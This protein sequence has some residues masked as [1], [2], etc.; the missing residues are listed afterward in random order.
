MHQVFFRIPYIEWPIYGFGLMLFLAF[1]ACTWLASRRA[2]RVGMSKEIVQDFTI[3]IFIGGLLGARIFFI[4]LEETPP[5]SVGEFLYRLPR[6]W[7]G[8]IIF[9]GSVVGALIAYGLLYWF[10][11]RK[12]GISTLKLADVVAPSVALGLALGRLG[13][14]LNGCCYGQAA[15]ADCP[16]YAVHFP[17]SAPA[18]YALVDSG[19]QTAAGFTLPIKEDDDPPRTGVRIGTVDPS[20]AAYAAGLR[21]GDVIIALD[22]QEIGS[23]KDLDY[24]GN[25]QKW[26]RGKKDL[27]LK[28]RDSTNEEKSLT[29]QP[30]TIGLHPTQL[31][32]TVSM[33]LV[34]LL[35]LAYTPFKTRDGQVMVLMM[36]TY[37][38]HRYINEMLRNDSRPGPFEWK[39][40]VLLFGAGLVMALWLWTRPAQ[41]KPTWSVAPA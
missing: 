33:V 10:S 2:E 27:T 6:I 3:W 4:Y 37:A 23:A 15:C 24:L 14:F 29:F 11:F 1:L 22:G 30:R 5:A 9:Y 12:Q 17:L 16:V 19:A 35:L 26:P 31:Y 13:C 38:V 28:V 41:Y 7:E 25:F 20:S 39:A 8:G 36:L 21:D 18:R 32:E 34:M 40:S